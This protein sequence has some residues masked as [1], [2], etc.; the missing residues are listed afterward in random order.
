[1]AI[2]LNVKMGCRDLFYI[3]FKIRME[4]KPYG[5]NF[6]LG[7]YLQTI[8][9]LESLVANPLHL[10]GSFFLKY[11]YIYYYYCKLYN[12]IGK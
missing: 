12:W 10:E 11:I 6:E 1:M 8:L 3:V 4:D 7:V 2:T 5:I 9:R